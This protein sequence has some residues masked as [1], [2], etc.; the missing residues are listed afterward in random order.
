MINDANNAVER[1][2]AKLPLDHEE[3]S[4]IMSRE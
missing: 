2:N 1:G 3:L 4:R